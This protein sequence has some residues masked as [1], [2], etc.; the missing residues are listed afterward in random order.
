M[1]FFNFFNYCCIYIS[2]LI[3]FNLFISFI[4]TELVLTSS[5]SRILRRSIK[6]IKSSFQLSIFFCFTPDQSEISDNFRQ[7][8]TTG[9]NIPSWLFF[10]IIIIFFIFVAL[11]IFIYQNNK[12][13]NYF[14][15][16]D[17]SNNNNTNYYYRLFFSI[18]V[19]SSNCSTII[20]GTALVFAF[21]FHC[22][23]F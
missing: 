4:V 3:F 20:F 7:F 1:K 22:F 19:G 23:K 8:E 15:K 9:G 6:K 12:N 17:M 13:F 18:V 2:S 21:L 16:N 11:C 10:Y 5:I 14:K